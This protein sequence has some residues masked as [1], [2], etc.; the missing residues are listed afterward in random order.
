MIMLQGGFER[1]MLQLGNIENNTIIFFLFYILKFH[2]SLT[3]RLRL[4]HVGCVIFSIRRKTILKNIL[5]ETLYQTGMT[6]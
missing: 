6:W 4:Y 2:L 5:E 1:I 3:H